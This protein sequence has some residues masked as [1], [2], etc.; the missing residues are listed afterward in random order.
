[1]ESQFDLS[2]TNRKDH[3]H[4]PWII[5]VLKCL[6]K[7]KEEHDGQG[8]KVYAEKKEF[9]KMINGFRLQLDE[10]SDPLHV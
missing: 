10:V 9:K 3:K 6:R 8:P 7:W 4:I 1:V 5:I 2:T